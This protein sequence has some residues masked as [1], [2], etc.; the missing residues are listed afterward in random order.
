MMDFKQ[1]YEEN[2]RRFAIVNSVAQVVFLA[3]LAVP[4]FIYED[5]LF[6]FALF[7]VLTSGYFFYLTIKPKF[8]DKIWNFFK[9]IR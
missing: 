1:K 6:L 2:L 4:M 9:K 7:W 5:L 8:V 3:I